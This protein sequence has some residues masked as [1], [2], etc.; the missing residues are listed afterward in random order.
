MFRHK[1]YTS[2]RKAGLSL[3]WPLHCLP[4]FSLLLSARQPGSTLFWSQGRCVTREMEML[5]GALWDFFPPKPE[6]IKAIM[7]GIFDREGR[8]KVF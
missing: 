8:G 4:L 3:N 5:P 2:L 1:V 6:S 7:L